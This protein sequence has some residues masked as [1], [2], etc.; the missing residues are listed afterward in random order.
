MKNCDDSLDDLIIQLLFDKIVDLYG[1]DAILSFSDDEVKSAAEYVWSN[2]TE[3][4]RH[5]N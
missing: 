3:V 2:M 1:K 5:E 4:L